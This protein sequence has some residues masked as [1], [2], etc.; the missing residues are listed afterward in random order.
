MKFTQ[1]SIPHRFGLAGLTGLISTGFY[2]LELSTAFT[3]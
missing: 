1:R 3:N 2:R